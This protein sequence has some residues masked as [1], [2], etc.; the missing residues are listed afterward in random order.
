[1]Q[2]D[3]AS[4][5]L[6]VFDRYE[7]IAL[8]LVEIHGGKLEWRVRTLDGR[9]EAHLLR[10]PGRSA[11]D[12]FMADPVR[13]EAQPLWISCGARSSVEEVEPVAYEQL[14]HP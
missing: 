11:F 9:S 10:F 6:A 14:E 12:D 4:A 13:E 1:M 2:L 3:L 5:D 7:A 8:A